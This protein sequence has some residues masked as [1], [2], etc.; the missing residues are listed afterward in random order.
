MRIH[1]GVLGESR[2]AK[3]LENPLETHAS[4]ASLSRPGA[5]YVLR[6]VSGHVPD[7]VPR[8]ASR[9]MSRTATKV[10]RAGFR[11]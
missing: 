9:V 1:R 3:I 10:L 6:R 2:S 7:R 4:A 11:V 5:G 8:R